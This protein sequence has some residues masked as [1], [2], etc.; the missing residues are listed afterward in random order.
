MIPATRCPCPGCGKPLDL[1]ATHLQVPYR[2]HRWWHWREQR[3]EYLCPRC[4]AFSVLR[5]SPTG[6][7]L[8]L[9]L[10][11]ALG[12][13]LWRGWPLP[14]LGFTGLIAAALLFR[15]AV[16]LAASTH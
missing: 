4:G 5:L 13:G 3:S 10:A 15:H 1:S 11:G 9:A 8:Y 16:R 7:L 14:V 12:T 2:R 6:A